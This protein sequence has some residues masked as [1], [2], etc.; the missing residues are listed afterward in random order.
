MAAEVRF[1]RPPHPLVLLDYTRYDPAGPIAP[2]GIP[3][4]I[5]NAW[6]H[7][8]V[9]LGIAFTYAVTI[10]YLNT[11]STGVPYRIAKT[12]AFK[13]AV[14]LHN[15][16]LA[17][18]SLWTFVGMSQILHKV[19]ISPTLHTQAVSGAKEAFIGLVDS[20]CNIQDRTYPFGDAALGSKFASN[21]TLNADGDHLTFDM[22]DGILGRQGLWNAGLSYYGWIFYLSKFYEVL[23]TLIII[24][25]GRKSSTLQT[26]HHAGAMLSMWAGIRWMSPPIW[27]FCWYNAGI[28]ALMYTYYTVSAL[29]IRVP[30]S[31]KQTLTTM[32]ITQFLVGGSSAALY[33]FIMYSPSANAPFQKCLSSIGE[34]M[35]VVINVLYLTPLT[36]LF[37][38]FFIRTYLKSNS[39]PKGQKKVDVV[40]VIE[41]GSS[42]GV[43][44]RSGNATRRA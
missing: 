15:I 21:Y 43:N 33:L 17:V 34:E 41:K 27:I 40:P 16:V 20:M 24:A 4:N 10:H 35:A 28:H 36:Y 39:A 30:G 2:A 19:V 9:P 23:D 18:Y 11:L 22:A 7:P 38:R 32:Q 29:G 14:I 12:R 42:S 13:W 1:T 3:E 37:L 31:L 6:L 8:A 5:Y 26:Y 44:V 25:K